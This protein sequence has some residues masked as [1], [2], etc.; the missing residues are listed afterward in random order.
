MGR[1]RRFRLASRLP[2]P[3]VE[4]RHRTYWE[5]VRSAPHVGQPRAK[6]DFPKADATCSLPGGRYWVGL[7]PSAY[8]AERCDTDF[9]LCSGLTHRG[10]RSAVV[11]FPKPDRASEGPFDWDG[12]FRDG[13]L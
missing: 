3:R 11:D 6:V 12:R 9:Q 13:R 10:H 1:L 4:S 2:Q 5:S 8:R 7:R